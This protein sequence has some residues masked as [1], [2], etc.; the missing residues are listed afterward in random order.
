MRHGEFFS[1]ALGTKYANYQQKLSLVTYC[2]SK[3]LW[4]QLVFNEI[5]CLINKVHK[6]NITYREIGGLFLAPLTI[7]VGRIRI[8]YEVN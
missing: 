5:F 7:T 3:L 6:K 1:S 4:L 2:M 8:V